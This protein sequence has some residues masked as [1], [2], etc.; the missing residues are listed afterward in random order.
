MA[1]DQSGTSLRVRSTVVGLG[2]STARR[3]TI[4]QT[5]HRMGDALTTKECE[6]P[7]AAPVIR[8]LV[9]SIRHLA[10]VPALA[11][12]VVMAAPATAQQPG[13]AVPVAR[14]GVLRPGDVVRLR[15]WREPDLSGDFQVDERGSAVFPKIGPV[16]V[17]SISA[18]S[19]ESMLIG[20]YSTY[21]RNPSI[22]ITLL[23]RVNVLGSVRNPGLYPV[24]ATMTVADALALAGGVTPEGDQNRLDLRRAGRTLST[25][26]S[27]RTRI[28]DSPSGRATSSTSLS[29]AG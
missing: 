6:P 22:E 27:Q 14:D 21:L 10:A 28:S 4:R 3:G 2:R 17:A 9:R 19:L 15:I 23:R 11:A 16:P 12:A 25:H 1:G 7:R 8:S 26:L 20:V 24:D 29:A 13:A 18:D 5:R